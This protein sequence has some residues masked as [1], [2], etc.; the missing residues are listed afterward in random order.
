MYFYISKSS[1][2]SEKS[3]FCESSLSLFKWIFLKKVFLKVCFKEQ[4]F[5]GLKMGFLNK[6][7]KKVLWSKFGGH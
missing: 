1:I 5:P 2:I 7:N 3:S 4:L 6:V